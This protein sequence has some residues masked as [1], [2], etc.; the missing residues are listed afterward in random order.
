MEKNST[1]HTFIGCNE[2]KN[3]NG[4]QRVKEWKNTAF[5]MWTT[6]QYT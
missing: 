3:M 5:N 1:K 4:R 2:V 6:L